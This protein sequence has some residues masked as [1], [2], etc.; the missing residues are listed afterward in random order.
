IVIQNIVFALGIKAVFLLLGS[1]GVAS[2]WEAVFA[3]MGVALLAIFN[4][5]RVGKERISRIS[6]K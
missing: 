3:D 6:G 5:M 1:L 4:A 2:M